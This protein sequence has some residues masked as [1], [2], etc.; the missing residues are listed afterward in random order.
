[1]NTNYEEYAQSAAQLAISKGHRDNGNLRELLIWTTSKSTVGM[2][3]EYFSQHHSDG[4]LLAALIEIA[5]EGEDMGDAPWAAAN[6][7]V[8]F[9]PELLREHEASL[10]TLSEYEWTYLNLP[11]Q[12]ALEKLQASTE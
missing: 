10:V 12:K 5:L 8:D 2:V 11:A 6:T 3:K 9:P 1:M 4:E 7:I